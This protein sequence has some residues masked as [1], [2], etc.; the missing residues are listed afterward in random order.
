MSDDLTVLIAQPQKPPHIPNLSNSPS[1]WRATSLVIFLISFLSLIINSPL[2]VRTMKPVCISFKWVSRMSLHSRTRSFSHFI[3][4]QLFAI[5]S[6]SMATIFTSTL[7]P[8]SSL[9][10]MMIRPSLT[11]PRQVSNGMPVTLA[12]SWRDKYG[13]TTFKLIVMLSIETPRSVCVCYFHAA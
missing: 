5:A 12:Y 1:T 3:K 4:P 13:V 8:E 7:P 9:G 2:L 6:L 11:M 10:R